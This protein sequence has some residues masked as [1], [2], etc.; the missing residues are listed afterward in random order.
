MPFLCEIA[1]ECLDRSKK[2]RWKSNIN[3]YC[4]PVRIGGLCRDWECRNIQKENFALK[5]TSLTLKNFE[6]GYMKWQQRLCTSVCESTE[7]WDSAGVYQKFLDVL[8]FKKSPCCWIGASGLQ[9]K[10]PPSTWVFSFLF[11]IQRIGMTTEWRRCQ[12]MWSLLFMV[13]KGMQMREVT[14]ESN[15]LLD[16]ETDMYVNWFCLVCQ[17]SALDTGDCH[18]AFRLH[19]LTFLGEHYFEEWNMSVG[20]S[21]SQLLYSKL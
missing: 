15:G 4:K 21:I 3:K 20:A 12:L 17:G 9:T 1:N 18:K 10:V 19:K 8:S 14:L 6:D 5:I 2:N 7:A 13:A 11:C 16:T